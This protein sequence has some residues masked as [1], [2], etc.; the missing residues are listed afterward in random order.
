MKIRCTI[1]IDE[2]DQMFSEHYGE[3]T[4][5]NA[6]SGGVDEKGMCVYWYGT[7]HYLVEF[8]DVEVIEK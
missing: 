8:K 7:P 2:A 3:A 5:Y 6:G 4:N 1:D